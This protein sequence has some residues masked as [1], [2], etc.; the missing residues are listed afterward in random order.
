M[1]P[2]LCSSHSIVGW[3]EITSP[4]YLYVFAVLWSYLAQ[5]WLFCSQTATGVLFVCRQKDSKPLRNWKQSIFAH[6]SVLCINTERICGGL[7]N[8]NLRSSYICLWARLCACAWLATQSKTDCSNQLN[9]QPLCKYTEFIY[10]Y[11]SVLLRADTWKDVIKL[12]FD[13]PTPSR[14]TVV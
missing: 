11:I 3:T 8:A 9:L 10:R 13:A 7:R 5:K 6:P 12:R 1:E 2:F 4:L 14:I